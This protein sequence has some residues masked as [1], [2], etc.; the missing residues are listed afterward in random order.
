MS[1]SDSVENRIAT[2]LDSLSQKQTRLARF[3]L[4]SKY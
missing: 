1:P 3:V 2:V 4:D